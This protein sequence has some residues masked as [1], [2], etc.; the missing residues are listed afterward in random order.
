MCASSPGGKAVYVDERRCSCGAFAGA[1]SVVSLLWPHAMRYARAVAYRDD[2]VSTQE[3]AEQL[4]ADLDDERQRVAELRR[5]VASRDTQLDAL[6]QKFNGMPAAPRL[7]LPVVVTA[8]FILG[9]LLGALLDLSNT[10]V[11]AATPRP[12]S[13]TEPHATEP[14]I[15]IAGDHEGGACNCETR[16][17]ACFGDCA[18]AAPRTRLEGASQPSARRFNLAANKSRLYDKVASGSG[19]ESDIRQ[20]E[21]LCMLDGDRGCRAMAVQAPEALKE[22]ARDAR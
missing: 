7:R 6:R 18:E 8:V 21:A 17:A 14:G 20:L 12:P 5:A 15:A 2:L 1:T 3:R 13:P 4:E 16:D 10:P 19:T 11:Q 22:S 9:V